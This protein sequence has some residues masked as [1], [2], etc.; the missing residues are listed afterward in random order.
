MDIQ[1]INQSSPEF[2]YQML[3]RL[4]ADCLYYLGNGGRFAGHLWAGNEREQIKLIW[5]RAGMDERAADQRLC[6]ANAGGI[7]IFRVV[8]KSPFLSVIISENE[9][10]F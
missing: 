8:S 10:R 2:L 9:W 6:G 4:E 3:G 5:S 1:E 7:K